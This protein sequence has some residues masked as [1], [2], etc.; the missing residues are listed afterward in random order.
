MAKWLISFI[1]CTLLFFTISLGCGNE[2][3]ALE[4]NFVSI[5]N[6]IRGE[7]FFEGKQA[8]EVPVLGQMEILKKNNL[9]ATWL[10]RYDALNLPEISKSLKSIPPNHEIGLFMEVTPTWT[11]AAGVEYHKT[12]A[13]HLPGSVFLTGY[14]PEDRNKLIDKAFE[15]FKKVFGNYPKSVG[16]WWID[17][18]SLD[19]MNQ[20]FKISGAMIVADQYSTDNYQIWGQYFSTPYYPDKD[21]VINPAQSLDKKLPVV[22]TQWAARDPVNGYGKGVEESTY[23]VQAND[24]MDFHNLGI[25]YFSKLLDIYTN[26]K[27]NDFGQLIM[28]L[29]NSYDWERYKT[30]Y[31]KQVEL[32]AE[33]K[34]KGKLSVITMGS[35]SGWYLSKFPK[36]SP[37]QI[38]VADD[39]LGSGKK[40]IWFMDPYYRAA[41]FLNDSGNS[42]KDLR[43]YIEG[44]FEL[45][46]SQACESLNFA[47]S[48][49]RVLDFVTFGHKW[50]IDEGNVKNVNVFKSGEKYV[51][52]YIN[53]AGNKR[54]I[55]F[56]PR[57]I[58]VDGKISSIDGAILASTFN[59]P[60]DKKHTQE[61]KAD[62]SS[63]VLFGIFVGFIKFLV[64]L[65]IFVIIPGY[66]ILKFTIKK[67]FTKSWILFLSMGLGLSSL[68]LLSYI[69][70]I[71]EIYFLMY[72]YIILSF[73]S[74]WFLKEKNDFSLPRINLYSLVVLT[75]FIG[76]IIFQTLPVFKSGIEYNFGVGFWGPN[77]HDGVWHLS[78]I[79]N[80][81]GKLPPENPVFSGQSL[82]NYHYFYDLL[83]SATSKLSLIS[84]SDLL[85]RFYPIL[86]SFLLG[87]GA[88]ILSLRLFNSK[89]AAVL[90]I[91]SVYF[92]GSFGFIVEFIREKHFG[93]ESAFWS[94]QPVSFNL[95]PPFAASLILVILT[96]L[97]LDIFI[98][99]KNLLLA[100][101]ILLII[102]SLLQFK[103]YSA[104]LILGTLFIVGFFRIFKKDLTIFGLAIFGGFVTLG[105]LVLNYDL[106]SLFIAS[107]IFVFA[108][109]WLV[110]SMVDSPDRVGWVRL[111][112][113]RTVGLETGN[114]FKFLAAE[115]IGL[116][117]FLGGNL[118]V[119]IFGFSNLFNIYRK[120][121]LHL[122]ITVF[123]FLAMLIPL[124]FI[125]KGT[126]WNTI[127]FMYYLLFITAIYAGA[128]LSWI[129]AK[130]PKV[131]GISILILV[132][133]IGPINAVVTAKGYLYPTPHTFISQKEL[134]GLNFLKDQSDGVVLTYPYDKSLK[135]K[136]LEP[137]PIFAY[138]TTAYVSAYSGKSVFL[139]DEIQND[140]LQTEYK[141]RVVALKDFIQNINSL[142]EK[143]SGEDIK[144]FLDE[145]DIRYIYLPK[146]HNFSLPEN[147]FGLTNIFENNEVVIYKYE[148]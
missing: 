73:I 71:F 55:E 48:A 87:L 85:F 98:K 136:L 76:G 133:V 122:F 137:L 77:A 111:S 140:I 13:W 12:Q 67:E 101:V 26:Q 130:L 110:H 126:P 5:V 50:D 56:L 53:E 135:E 58:S 44:D 31:G 65:I 63:F 78:L 144:S 86:L 91:Y 139:E 138:E 80:L 128:T 16:A 28:G 83:I 121:F 72:L 8:P 112:L 145:Y 23:S 129:Y 96:F 146:T 142:N 106:N 143:S 52:E 46:F 127:Q 119:R 92:F 37:A 88:Y 105:L 124:L 148:S 147:K 93:G 99:R 54:V 89:T 49:T 35:F 14:S 42:F 2:V 114:W 75:I 62:F 18:H 20:K 90:G 9:S 132:L 94:N 64:F 3:F 102:G 125:Q 134:S 15:D 60:A 107:S 40:S 116:I 57:D 79:N 1:I 45:C 43:Q 120:D 104:I 25:N 82:I 47:T 7:D 6:P 4:N 108:P 34:K 113:A 97:L 29:E 59:K 117:V 11:N 84:G 118:G 17:G 81:G 61:L 66:V 70:G 21:R 22:I 103:A 32:L 33:N 100:V 123:S 30:E 19:Y 115:T 69:S 141:K 109:F 95:N 27:F 36:L 51:V 68:V 24:Y 38:I 74:F 10:V 39:P 41:L 131:F